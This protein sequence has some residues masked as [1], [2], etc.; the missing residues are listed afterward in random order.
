MGISNENKK[1]DLEH[2]EDFNLELIV[3]ENEHTFLDFPWFED[4]EYLYLSICH[5]SLPLLSVDISVYCHQG[6]II[7][8][9]IAFFAPL[10]EDEHKSKN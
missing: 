5:H 9:C 8:F 6:L 10:N 7:D 3:F 4:Q 1:D 2:T